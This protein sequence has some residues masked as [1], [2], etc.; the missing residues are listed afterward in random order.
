MNNVMGQFNS[1][2]ENKLF[3]LLEEAVWE[4]DKK[5]ASHLKAL[6]TE[7][8]LNIERKYH[9]VHKTDNFL[10]FILLSN[11]DKVVPAEGGSRR[12]TCFETSDKY[13]ANKEYFANFIA[14]VNDPDVLHSFIWELFNRDVSEFGRGQA[15]PVTELLIKQ[16][17]ASM[18]DVDYWWNQCLLTGMHVPHD[19]VNDGL[20]RNR[21]DMWIT[22]ISSHD[23]YNK[24]LRANPHSRI[25]TSHFSSQFQRAALLKK[26]VRQV[27]HITTS[28][29]TTHEKRTYYNLG[30]LDECRAAMKSR[31]VNFKYPDDDDEVPETPQQKRRRVLESALNNCTPDDIV[32]CIE[33]AKLVTVLK[34]GTQRTINDNILDRDQLRQTLSKFL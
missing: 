25:S 19:E 12:Y 14:Q 17:E 5:T 26:T 3:I 22:N 10:N 28:K 29:G 15:N 30:T 21:D 34:K 23:L 1:V 16:Q 9:D 32:G 24:F 6:L 31:Y 8:W 2:L 7:P 13:R 20:I 18:S 11:S 4:G 27:V 33:P